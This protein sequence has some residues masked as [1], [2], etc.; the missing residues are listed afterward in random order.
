M[1]FFF[2]FFIPFLVPKTFKMN[3]CD[4][5]KDF[6]EYHTKLVIFSK[7]SNELV[8]LVIALIVN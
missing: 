2:F 6:G 1:Y 8:I 3:V 4:R 5:D 7:A